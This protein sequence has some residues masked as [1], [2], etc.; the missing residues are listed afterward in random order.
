M[1]ETLT[2]RDA[3]KL[4]STLSCSDRVVMGTLPGVC[5]AGGMTQCL[6]PHGARIFD[7]PDFAKPPRGLIGDTAARLAPEVGITMEHTIY[8]NCGSLSMC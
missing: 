8:S 6:A 7:C 3:E 1:S 4:S 5:Y 2:K